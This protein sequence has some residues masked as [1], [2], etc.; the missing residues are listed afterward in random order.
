MSVEIIKQI[1]A[2]F[3]DE[4]FTY[5]G[6]STLR[7]IPF[8]QEKVEGIVIFILKNEEPIFFTQIPP[9]PEETLNKIISEFKLA[10]ETEDE[11]KFVETRE[12]IE[13]EVRKLQA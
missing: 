1:I 9:L 5:P 3:G 12:M 11:Q 13:A 4:G 2:Q 6:K 10:I 8:G 7:V